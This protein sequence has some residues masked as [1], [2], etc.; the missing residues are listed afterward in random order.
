[1]EDKKGMNGFAQAILAATPIAAILLYFV[2]TGQQ[3]VRTDQQVRDVK[4]DIAMT[5]FDLA[6]DKM[7]NEI[8]GTEMT[9]EELAAY[10]EKLKQLK[11]KQTAWEQQFDKE[12]EDMEKDL[13]KLKE[14]FKEEPA[15]PEGEGNE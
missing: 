15:K 11:L 2:M 10:Q 1:M 6:F 8:D 14:A 3:Q 13:L 5:E 7:N 12:F 9:P 4:Q